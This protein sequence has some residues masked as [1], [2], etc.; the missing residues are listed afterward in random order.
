MFSN[1]GINPLQFEF[2]DISS[3]LYSQETDSSEEIVSDGASSSSDINSWESDGDEI[4]PSEIVLTED[5]TKEDLLSQCEKAFVSLSLSTLII[6]GS[7]EQP[8]TTISGEDLL[9]LNKDN[10]DL[11]FTLNSLTL[12]NVA[13]LT[14]DQATQFLCQLEGI[15]TLKI[16]IPLSTEQL[17]SIRNKH[18]DLEELEYD[19]PLNDDQLMAILEIPGLKSLNLGVG[20]NLT[21]QSISF[22]A[23]HGS[24]FQSLTIGFC[25][26]KLSFDTMNAL[27]ASLSNLKDL[28]LSG[29]NF[30]HADHLKTLL[31][32]A[33]AMTRASLSGCSMTRE[34]AQTVFNEIKKPKKLE[35]FTLMNEEY[36]TLLQW[37]LKTIKV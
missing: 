26:D 15:T 18:P 37:N 28:Y 22:L 27:F 11:L 12:R 14:A 20:R 34:T 10:P 16:D 21:D 5:C 30:I 33:N 23:K 29:K 2:F 7:N 31:S 1:A 17:I 8:V 3:K 9:E 32:T 36:A 6:R 19:A 13:N 35:R 24:Q 25:S 4:G